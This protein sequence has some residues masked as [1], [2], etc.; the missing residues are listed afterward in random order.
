MSIK[1]K[2]AMKGN[3]ANKKDIKEIDFVD[4]DMDKSI[5]IEQ[6]AMLDDYFETIDIDRNC[7]FKG[8]E[9]DLLTLPLRSGLDQKWCANPP[10]PTIILNNGNNGN[11][12]NNHHHRDDDGNINVIITKYIAPP[13]SNA[14]FCQRFYQAYPYMKGIN[15]HGMFIAGGSISRLVKYPVNH[16]FS[17]YNNVLYSD[18]PVCIPDY[19]QDVQHNYNEHSGS[20]SIDLDVFFY[21][22][23]AQEANA[24]IVEINNHLCKY[25]DSHFG[26]SVKTNPWD[27]HLTKM[28]IQYSINKY[29][30]TIFMP[31]RPIQPGSNLYNFGYQEIQ[32]IFRLYASK[33]EI[34]HGFDLG[35]CAVGFDGT[36]LYFTSLSKFAFEYGLNIIDTTRRS[37]SYEWRLSKYM[38]RGFNIVIPQ[39]DMVEIC[40]N[41]VSHRRERNNNLYF[42]LSEGAKLIGFPFMWLIVLPSANTK[43]RKNTIAGYVMPRYTS[44][45]FIQKS[46]YQK[47][48]KP[49][50]YS[51][52][53]YS[54]YDKLNYKYLMKT[55]ID[56][57]KV[58]GSD[59][60]K[61]CHYK[62][63][64]EGIF[65]IMDEYSTKTLGVLEKLNLPDTLTAFTLEMDKK[66]Q[67]IKDQLDQISSTAI[68]WIVENPGSQLT[69]SINPIFDHEWVWY[70]TSFYNP[71]GHIRRQTIIN[72]LLG[73]ET[74]IKQLMLFYSLERHE[75]NSDQKKKN[76]KKQRILAD[77]DD[78]ADDADD[79]AEYADD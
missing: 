75:M 6:G 68:T 73:N 29:V 41:N 46:D 76:P 47:T 70:G 79:D 35:S 42:H 55:E 25:H 56:K 34:L 27:S 38:K 37:T 18:N 19:G 52:T 26:Q 21:G 11:I 63:S 60:D 33:S 9:G 78:D 77:A 10:V 71:T 64:C 62:L 59:F 44:D 14:D 61:I 66:K 20:K 40:K 23:S 48:P 5:K 7:R 43:W 50:I 58:Y 65:E 1:F 36:Q 31:I 24:R 15:W 8:V 28:K 67:L 51:Q 22:I 16:F 13:V 17:S 32:L 30:M 49:C 69:S 45:Y 57:V 72:A 4:N 54:S 39:L 74:A 2:S 53:P 3:K 12:P